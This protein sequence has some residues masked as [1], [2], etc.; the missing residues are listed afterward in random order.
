M[1]LKTLPQVVI[2]V[3]VSMATG[4]WL[5]LRNFPPADAKSYG[6]VLFAILCAVAVLYSSWYIKRA[7]QNRLAGREAMSPAALYEQYFQNSGL[8]QEVV[9]RLW[10]SAAQALK[11][12]AELLRPTDRFDRELQPMAEWH[13]HDDHNE[14]LAAWAEGEAKK[15][16]TK[17]DLM[18]VQTLGELITLIA[19][20]E[21][22]SP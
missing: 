13:I 14:R 11:L 8:P 18:P 9:I 10:Q 17:I 12:P 22:G 1:K 15:H 20:L 4:M 5:L 21:A 3:V 7:R 6:A 2:L 16:G 19:R